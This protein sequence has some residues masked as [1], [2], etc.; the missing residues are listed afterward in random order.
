MCYHMRMANTKKPVPRA[1]VEA[2]RDRK[3]HIATRSTMYVVRTLLLI[4]MGCIVCIAAFLTAERVANLYILTNE[5][6]ALR[7][8]CILADGA[9]NDLEEYFTLTYLDTD[10]AL[11]DTT[12]DAYTIS[13]YN[14]D[15]SIRKLSVLPWSMTATVT[16][17]ERI[18]IKGAINASLL[19]EGDNAENYPLPAWT[20]REYRI[21]F[22]NGDGR[23]FING[24][25]VLT[26]NPE[27]EGLG[28]PDPN[29]S[30]IPAA[31][32][33]P[34]PTDPPAVLP[35]THS[36]DEVTTVS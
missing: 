2:E 30:P 20:P 1:A 18:T 24:L 7:A 17:V 4:I 3:L 35:S 11:A 28:T 16:A 33:T 21:D 14:Y 26:E 31:T 9:K 5:G 36:A 13:S 8:E 19:E 27:I 32:P 23:W 12:Y 34:A 6:M 10:T 22:V 15:L 29:R 25:T